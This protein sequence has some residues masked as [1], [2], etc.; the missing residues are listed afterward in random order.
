MAS[1]HQ[2]S[3]RTIKAAARR[4]AFA[5]AFGAASG[6]AMA[7]VVPTEPWMGIQSVKSRAEVVAELK[8]ARADGAMEVFNE[9]YVE[10]TRPTLT[11]AQVVAEL[12]AARSRGESF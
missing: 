2:P 8:Q 3:R 5:L 9:A 11:R 4:A 6:V 12:L 10:A 1:Q 7:Q